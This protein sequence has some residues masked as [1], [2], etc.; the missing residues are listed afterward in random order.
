M[1]ERGL[2]EVEPP[3]GA[4]LSTRLGDGGDESEVTQIEVQGPG[5]AVAFRTHE[6]HS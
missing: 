3:S 6:R 5:G 1:T 2:R 4:G